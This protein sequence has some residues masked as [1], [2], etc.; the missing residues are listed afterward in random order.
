MDNLHYR[1]ISDLGKSRPKIP[2]KNLLKVVKF[3]NLVKK[4]LLY[5][6]NIAL[7]SLQNFY[8]FVL[9][10]EIVTIFE[11]KEVIISARNTILIKLIS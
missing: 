3:K 10:V 1:L 8:I 7:Q 9:R 5:A 11:P 6:E 4:M 2:G